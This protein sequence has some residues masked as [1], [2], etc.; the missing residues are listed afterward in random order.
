[1]FFLF[2]ESSTI[3]NI[4]KKFIPCNSLNIKSRKNYKKFAELVIKKNAHPK[5]LILGGGVLGHGM[6]DIIKNTQIEF[7]ETDVSLGPRTK[8]IC[9]AHD[10]PFENNSFDGVIVQAVL[11]HVADPY[12][13]VSEIHRVIKPEG[14][15]YA[16]TPFIQQ[17]HGRQYDFT[18]FTFLGHR[19]LFRYFTEIDSGMAGGP[20]MAL[21]WSYKYFLLSFVKGKLLRKMVSAWADLTSFYIKYFDFILINKKSSLDA[22]SGFYFI[23]KKSDICLNDREILNLYRGG[24]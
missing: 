1:M 4:L 21:A 17:V 24:F 9:D 6:Q 12:R 13:C 16:D 14:Y 8:M 19:R 18:R 10:I 15:V 20:G 11:E 22:A 23:G 3:K 7:I 2:S 5:V